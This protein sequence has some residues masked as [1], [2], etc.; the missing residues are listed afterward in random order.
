[1]AS[2]PIKCFRDLDAWKVSME[3]SLAAGVVVLTLLA[4]L[5]ATAFLG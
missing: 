1:M 4:C 2:E 3:L 5:A